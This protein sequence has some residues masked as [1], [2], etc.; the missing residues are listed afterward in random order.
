MYYIGKILDVGKYCF[1]FKEN[2]KN[3][4]EQQSL[5]KIGKNRIANYVLIGNAGVS[6]KQYSNDGI[7]DVE[8][9]DIVNN[10]NVCLS[11]F[12]KR[13]L[14]IFALIL[15]ILASFGSLPST[16]DQS[17]T[18]YIETPL[19]VVLPFVCLFLFLRIKK[20]KMAYLAYDIS[21]EKEQFIQD[22]YDKLSKL[23]DAEKV[24]IVKGEE[25]H[26]DGRRHAGATSGVSIESA[27]IHQSII[28]GLKTNAHILAIENYVHFFPDALFLYKDKKIRAI[29]YKDIEIQLST[30]NFRE[31]GVV[32]SDSEKIGST[33]KYVNNDGSPDRRFNDNRKIP[34]LKYCGIKITDNNG[35]S[36]SLLVSNYEIGKN[37]AN[38]VYAYKQKT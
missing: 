13:K 30:S 18:L 8:H 33:W 11:K 10:I 20:Y 22:F 32:P 2:A 38:A 17:E 28:K 34:I 19:F 26:D 1:L 15:A 29:S 24:W 25:R 27:S 3:F 35:F 7:E 37:F 6:Y 21:P 31:S 4:M 14:L 5:S 16:N 9:E 23:E 36:L 12:S